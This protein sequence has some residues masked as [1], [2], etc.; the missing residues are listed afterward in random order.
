VSAPCARRWLIP[1]PIHCFFHGI[2]G[3]FR[4]CMVIDI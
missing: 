1:D 4:S 3:I 2:H